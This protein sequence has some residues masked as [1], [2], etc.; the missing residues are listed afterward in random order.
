MST[1]SKPVKIPTKKD[2]DKAYVR[3]YKMQTVGNIDST[4]RTSVPMDVIER[5]AKNRSLSVQDFVR[6]HKVQWAYNGFDGVWV[7]FIPIDDK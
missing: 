6:T 3:S 7:T 4:A 1:N 2:I 5:E